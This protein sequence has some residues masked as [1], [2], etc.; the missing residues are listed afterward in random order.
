MLL[1]LFLFSTIYRDH[2][3]IIHI[4]VSTQQKGLT[5]KENKFIV[6][7]N[8]YWKCKLVHPPDR[9]TRLLDCSAE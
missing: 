6:K 4:N 8:Q 7:V 1:P 2:Q 5:M 9:H 3:N